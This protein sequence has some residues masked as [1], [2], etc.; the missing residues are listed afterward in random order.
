MYLVGKLI[1]IFYVHTW[2]C[3]LE[4]DLECLPQLF[5]CLMVFESLS[6]NLELAILAKLAVF[7]PPPFLLHA[8]VTGLLG[9]VSVHLTHLG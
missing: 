9:N 2:V 4:M 3:S 5:L 8:V 6:L 1:D 7:D